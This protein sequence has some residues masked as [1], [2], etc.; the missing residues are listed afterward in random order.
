[1]SKKVTSN[2]KE[3]KQRTYFR[4]WRKY[5]GM[6]QE[7][8]ASLVGV[9]TSSISQLETNKQGFTDTTLFALAAALHCNAGDLLMRNPLDEE[10]PWSIWDNIPKKQRKQAIQIL[11]TFQNSN[12]NTGTNG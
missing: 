6:N 4:E 2:F 10:A 8:L 11:K 5:R 12:S 3:P 7:E 9:S 1:M